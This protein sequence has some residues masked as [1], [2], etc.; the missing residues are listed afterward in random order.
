[1][2]AVLVILDKK[3]GKVKS[4]AVKLPDSSEGESNV[5]YAGMSI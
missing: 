2:K 3:S 1:M 5:D 4:V